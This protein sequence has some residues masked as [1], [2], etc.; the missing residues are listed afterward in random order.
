VTATDPAHG[1]VDQRFV[2]V[3]A[4]YVFMLRDGVTGTEVLL[5]LRQGTGYMDGHWGAGAAG[6]VEK[7][8]T[9]YDAAQREALEEIAVSDVALEF[10]TAMQRTRGGEP[11]DE[12]IDF[13]FTARSWSGEPRILEAAKAADLGWFPLS[14]LPHP[15]VPH[16]L[17]V[18]T[19]II[20][21]ELPAYT[22]FGFERE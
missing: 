19:G 6:H 9:A 21:G 2:V 8:E 18:L 4:A 7:G 10:V 3:P 11:I 17:Q 20:E 16:E 13:F 5:Q 15:V 1:T 22:T 12:R 14:G